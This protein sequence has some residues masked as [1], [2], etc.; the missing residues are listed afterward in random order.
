MASALAPTSKSS[1]DPRENSVSSSCSAEEDW[2][3]FPSKATAIR[4]RSL[5]AMPMRTFLAARSMLFW[6]L[7]SVVTRTPAYP[8]AR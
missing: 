6:T 1:Y 4:L 8:S 5:M 3:E 2:L 7:K